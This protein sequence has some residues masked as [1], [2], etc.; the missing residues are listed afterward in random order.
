G[1]AGS[2][3]GNDTECG[4]VLAEGATCFDPCLPWN[5]TEENAN[6][7]CAAVLEQQAYDGEPM[8]F[9]IDNHPEALTQP[10][11]YS[12]AKVPAQYGY[13][14]WPWET[15]EFPDAP[16]HNFHFTTEVRYWFQ[17][18]AGQTVRLDFTGDDD[19]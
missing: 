15:D 14:G 9:P 10:A 3:C 16:L 8:F 12:E 19:V 2:G 4:G 5:E 18:A 7:S 11:A 6:N 17:Y 13:I 1:D